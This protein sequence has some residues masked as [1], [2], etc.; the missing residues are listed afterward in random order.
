[1]D[2]HSLRQQ[3]VRLWRTGFSQLIDFQEILDFRRVFN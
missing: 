2:K 1:M 3:D